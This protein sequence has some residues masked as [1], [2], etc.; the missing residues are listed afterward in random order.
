M[1]VNGLRIAP[2]RRRAVAA[3]IDVL[4]CLPPVAG[5]VGLGVYL[6]YRFRGRDEEG[7]MPRLPDPSRRWQV[8]LSLATIASAVRWRNTRGVGARVMGLRRVDVRTGGPVSVRSALI[9]ATFGVGV[10]RFSS[11]WRPR[12]VAHDAATGTSGSCGRAL[13][14]LVALEAPALWPPLHQDI[15]DRLAGI[16]VIV[17]E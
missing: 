6:A 12:A 5:V 11:R 2:L 15:A 16:V 8:L 1:E 9:R 7:D 10:R 3:A 17:E 4:V 13:L 14:L